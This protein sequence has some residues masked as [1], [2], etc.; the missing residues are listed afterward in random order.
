MLKTFV[1]R[2]SDGGIRKLKPLTTINSISYLIAIGAV[3]STIEV[4]AQNDEIQPPDVYQ[5]VMQVRGELELIRVEMGRSTDPR[6]ELGV[7]NAAPREVFFQALTMHEKTSRL[8]LE[9]ASERP[10]KLGL[11]EGELTP[12]E[13]HMV[14]TATHELLVKVKA[15]LNI[16]GTID[17]QPRE[18]ERTPT[19]VFRAII[20]ANRQLNLLLDQRLSP[21]DVFRE[22]TVAIDYV[23]G[24][25]AAFPEAKRIPPEP[26]F[27]SG[28][29]PGDV[30][31][32]LTGCFERIRRIA[33]LSNLSVLEL[34]I[35][36]A[37]VM[38]IEPS[39]VFDLAS[40]T[41]SEL[42]WL[43]RQLPNAPPVRQS[44]AVGGKFPSHVF[45]RVG[46][47]E[48]QLIELEEQVE[49]DPGWLR[50]RVR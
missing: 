40:L 35:A 31:Q 46:I 3:A 11:P 24:L 47:L 38:E 20:Q 50:N 21:N 34:D 45:Q 43:H 22:V 25:L 15:D 41:V 16:S 28:K 30:Y 27:R 44:Y 13:V 5:K 48:A 12:A 9:L 7:R 26:V 39:D 33:D 2:Q 4:T 23:S 8:C 6:P 1:I 19:D 36:G 49:V 18:P 32:R 10:P 42:A 17:L 14:A 29:Q 37:E